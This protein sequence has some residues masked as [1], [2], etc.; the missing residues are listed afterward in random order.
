M[1]GGRYIVTYY[2][3]PYVAASLGLGAL[4]ENSF[5]VCLCARCECDWK[6][7]R[8]ICCSTETAPM[9]GCRNQPTNKDTH[10]HKGHAGGGARP[11]AEH[12]IW[13]QGSRSMWRNRWGSVASAG[14]GSAQL[15][16]N[17]VVV[18]AGGALKAETN[19]TVMGSQ[20]PHRASREVVAC[21][22][23][24]RVLLSALSFG[25]VRVHGRVVR[26]LAHGTVISQQ[27]ECSR[28]RAMDSCV[29]SS[30]RGRAAC[31]LVDDLT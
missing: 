14:R 3:V 29:D 17:S 21:A 26:A 27:A 25:F 5:D 19:V 9:P 20:L 24:A 6:N 7:K 4:V 11:R 31:R 30:R 8:H 23:S 12:V 13:A 18:A 1:H 16:S 15:G 28:G 22:Q 10:T 2:L